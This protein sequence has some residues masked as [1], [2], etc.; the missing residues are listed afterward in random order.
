[1][2]SAEP[3][4]KS[5]QG[6]REAAGDEAA[7]SPG[8]PPADAIA[9]EQHNGRA[10]LGKPQRRRQAGQ[11]AAD[12]TNVDFKIA[13]QGRARLT[14][15]RRAR[16]IAIDVGGCCQI[17]YSGGSKTTDSSVQLNQTC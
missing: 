9:F 11:A 5:L 13:P 6:L 17:D 4:L 7:V 15:A 1:M 14:G 3:L 8:R 2:V 10:P 12:Y 16:V